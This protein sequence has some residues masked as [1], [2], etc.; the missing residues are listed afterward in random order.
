MFLLLRLAFGLMSLALAGLIAL[1]LSVPQDTPLVTGPAEPGVAAIGRARALLRHHDPRRQAPTAPTQL[2]LTQAEVDLLLAALPQV[3]PG[4]HARLA[5]SDANAQ[6]QATLPLPANPL[7]TYLNLRCQLANDGL[8]IT[9]RNLRLGPV[10][11]PDAL[12]GPLAA[13]AWSALREHPDLGIPTRALTQ[14]R[15]EKGAVLLTYRLPEALPGRLGELALG[16]EELASLRIY[17]ELLAKTLGAARQ[18][19][20][21]PDVLTPLFQQARLRGGGASEYRAALLVV[22]AHLAGRPLSTLLPAARDWS[23][24]PRRTVTLAGRVDSAQH[25]AVSALLAAHAGTPLANA[26]GLWKELEDSRGGSG[27]SFADLAADQAGTRLGEALAAGDA[28]VAGR[29]ASGVAE[30]ELL[31]RLDDLPENLGAAAFRARY[32]QPGDPRYQT[33][34]REIETRVAALPLYR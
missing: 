14:A 12:A 32:G 2:R 8:G 18:P 26:V 13:L 9:P 22:G 4:L 34:E 33:L 11:V 24:L 1:A 10:P 25:F 5:L 7:G 6:L 20:P 31:P 30:P 15:L 28:R 17:H 29:L 3:L 27:F 19:L 23:V 21:L 16:P